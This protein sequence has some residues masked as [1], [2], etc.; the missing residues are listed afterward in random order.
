[1]N[2]THDYLTKP[3]SLLHAT[4]K[5][6][7]T[8]FSDNTNSY[9]L[10]SDAIIYQYR[11]ISCNYCQPQWRLLSKAS[12]HVEL[13]EM[14]IYYFRISKNQTAHAN[15]IFASLRRRQRYRY[16]NKQSTSLCVWHVVDN[17]RRITTNEIFN[18]AYSSPNY[19]QSQLLGF[20]LNSREQPCRWYLAEYNHRGW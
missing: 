8:I 5:N 13:L 2:S 11:A 15:P 18:L 6:V 19:R 17:G 20:V 12:S 1:M 7:T 16:A 14:L 9:S 3:F 4:P 10:Y